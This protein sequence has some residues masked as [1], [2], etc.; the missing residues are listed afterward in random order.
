M[1]ET[2]RKGKIPNVSEY[3]NPFSVQYFGPEE[4]LRRY[5]EHVMNDPILADQLKKSW[6]VTFGCY[7]TGEECHGQTLLDCF[8]ELQENDTP[9]QK[10]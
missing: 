3:F 8:D 6:G 5:K 1:R 9:A 10:S 4:S 7:C 2:H